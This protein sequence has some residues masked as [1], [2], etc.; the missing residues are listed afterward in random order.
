LERSIEEKKNESEWTHTHLFVSG[1]DG[2]L[3]G[4]NKHFWC[5]L[6]RKTR[7]DNDR[8]YTSFLSDKLQWETKRVVYQDI[9]GD[10][11]RML[12]TG[13]FFLPT[14]EWEKD[15]YSDLSKSTSKPS[16]S[17]SKTFR[18]EICGQV[19]VSQNQYFKHQRDN[20]HYNQPGTGLL[21][22]PVPTS[23]VQPFT[24][25]VFSSSALTEEKI[26]GFFD[27]DEEVPEV[28]RESED[29]SLNK[30]IEFHSLCEI[31]RE[32]W[33]K[34][35]DSAKCLVILHY[36]SKKSKL[37][38]AQKLN[39]KRKILSQDSNL[40]QSFLQCERLNDLDGLLY[41]FVH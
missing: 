31:S 24:P 2:I 8:S 33:N 18:C 26:E 19:F 25:T 32:Q 27:E 13:S 41:S 3:T 5:S 39:S 17:T 29:Q 9:D 11:E 22:Q 12:I 15:V 28:V 6:C 35:L 40:M 4:Q 30:G 34:M 16:P 38:V 10:F 36:L 14:K 7:Q 37:S 21:T 23:Y 1:I 20:S